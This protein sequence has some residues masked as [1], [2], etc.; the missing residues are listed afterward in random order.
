MLLAKAQCVYMQNGADDVHGPSFCK[1]FY[2]IFKEVLL[3]KTK[4]E[5]GSSTQH[6]VTLVTTG[7]LTSWSSRCPQFL[8][9]LLTILPCGGA[10][11]CRH[12]AS[13]RWSLGKP[14]LDSYMQG[15][16]YMKLE[17]K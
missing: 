11:L 12:N 9:P 7:C 10:W 17:I 6:R 4:Q 3:R 8:S 2:Y 15:K 13:N 1:L 14:G 16:I 5:I